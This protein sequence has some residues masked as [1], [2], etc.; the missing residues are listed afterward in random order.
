MRTES[1]SVCLTRG[2]RQHESF[3]T[4]TQAYY[5]RK[6]V[7]GERVFLSASSSRKRA[8]YVRPCLPG[9]LLLWVADW[10][11]ADPQCLVSFGGHERGLAFV[12]VGR[13]VRVGWGPTQLLYLLW[14]H[15]ELWPWVLSSV[16]THCGSTLGETGRACSRVAGPSWD[17]RPRPR[18]TR[19]I[20]ERLRKTSQRRSRGEP[21]GVGVALMRPR[22]SPRTHLCQVQKTQTLQNLVFYIL[23]TSRKAST[24][25][26]SGNVHLWGKRL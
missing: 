3:E 22:T 18:R 24:S 4:L 20:S 10:Q 6:Y 9:W 2:G 5:V 26:P 16:Q 19:Q 8:P 1:D 14:G 15:S 11:S 13:R 23:K 21:D 7:C 25:K 17:S 12:G